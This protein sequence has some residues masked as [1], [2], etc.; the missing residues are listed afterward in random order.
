M[1]Y[2]I[3]LLETNGKSALYVWGGVYGLYRYL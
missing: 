1:T 2:I 3:T